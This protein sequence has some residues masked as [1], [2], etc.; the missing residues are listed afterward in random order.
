VK[1]A[2]GILKNNKLTH[3]KRQ[4]RLYHTVKKEAGKRPFLRG[5]S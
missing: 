4:Q 1:N 5:K 3:P 2:T